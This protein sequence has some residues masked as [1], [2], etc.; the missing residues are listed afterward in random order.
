V[1]GLFYFNDADITLAVSTPVVGTTGGRVILRADYTAATIRLAVKQNTDGV[2]AIPALTQIANDI[3]EIGLSEFTVTTGGVITVT[4]NRPF[5]KTSTAI[6]VS[7]GIDWDS[8]NRLGIADE[9]VTAAMAGAG[10]PNITQRQGGGAGATWFTP[11]TTNFSVSNVK[12][13]A[14]VGTATLLTGSSSVNVV[15]NLPT[16]FSIPPIVYITPYDYP[17]LGDSAARLPLIVFAATTTETTASFTFLT[18]DA[19]NATANITVN[20]SW[21]VLGAS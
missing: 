13:T 3:W 19:V 18:K 5:A 21:L 14:G 12:I 11:G 7:R 16:T 9:G 20:F 2:A 6:D 15:I 4:D 1:R 8:R 10:I 17:A